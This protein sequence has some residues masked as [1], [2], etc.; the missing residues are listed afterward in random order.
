[1]RIP[2]ASLVVVPGSGHALPVER[3]DEFVLLAERFLARGR[4]AD[5]A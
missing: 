3:E 5:A 4:E 1:M 2:G